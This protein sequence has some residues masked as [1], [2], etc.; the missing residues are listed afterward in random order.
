MI[1]F[2]KI[3]IERCEFLSKLNLDG[4]LTRLRLTTI[5]WGLVVIS[6]EN[7]PNWKGIKKLITKR[8]SQ[9]TFLVPKS[10]VITVKAT[11]FFGVTTK[12]FKSPGPNYKLQE[13]PQP[14]TLFSKKPY[15]ENI[16]SFVFKPNYSSKIFNHFLQHGAN[17]KEKEIKFKFNL[18]EKKLIFK[19]PK[20]TLNKKLIKQ[21]LTENSIKI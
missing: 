18:N 5:G 3:R 10:S 12:H 2:K 11:N 8:N 1:F 21:K 16:K 9:S 13:I 17:I 14:L 19:T 6:S 15:I 20:F 4:D 7:H